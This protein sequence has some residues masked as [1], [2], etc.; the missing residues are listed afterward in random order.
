MN[1]RSFRHWTGLCALLA[2]LVML[3]SAACSTGDSDGIASLS[4]TFSAN[5]VARNYQGV[6][7]YDVSLREAAGVGVQIQGFTV[8]AYD[9]AGAF[10]GE[11]FYS[12]GDFQNLFNTSSNYLPSGET[13]TSDGLTVS[14]TPGYRIWKFSGRDD[15][16][17]EINVSARVTFI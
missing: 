7:E 16:G 4:V 5:P 15:N 17:N 9:A 2:C 6:W 14:G 1:E 13:V 3:A 10:Q 11:T 8:S 12:S